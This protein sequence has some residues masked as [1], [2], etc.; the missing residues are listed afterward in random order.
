MIFSAEVAVVTFGTLRIIFVARGQKIVAPILG[1]FEILI[2]L[3]AISQ[4]MQNLSDWSCFVAFALGFTL[5]REGAGKLVAVFVG[6][7]RRLGTT[8]VGATLG[9]F[10]ATGAGVSGKSA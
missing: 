10:D 8:V 4:I 9:M 3:F 2:W 6:T 1:F 7:G 5:G